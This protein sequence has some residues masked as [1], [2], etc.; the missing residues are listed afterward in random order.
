MVS[1]RSQPRAARLKQPVE[2]VIPTTNHLE[3]FNGILK[4]KFIAQWEKA[5]HCL[6]FDVFIHHLV[7]KNLPQIFAR[8]RLLVHYGLWVDEHFHV[9]AGSNHLYSI[10]K[11][12]NAQA[13][14]TGC[15]PISLTW[16]EVDEH[17]SREAEVIL[18][19]KKLV[20]MPAHRPYE[21]W[22]T[23]VTSVAIDLS[24]PSYPW[25]NLSIHP[26]GSA[27]CSCADWMKRGG[28]CKH[29]HALKQILLH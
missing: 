17:H 5:G 19:Q 24:N 4:Q 11:K 23:C 13:L 29:L 9:A 1:A 3:S 28:V 7:C 2:G 25:Y 26:S 8:R 27:T 15:L 6:R 22:A 20:I 14:P 16:F 12:T 21:I 10:K 18:H